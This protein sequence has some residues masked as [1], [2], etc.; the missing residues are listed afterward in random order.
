MELEEYLEYVKTGQVIKANSPAHQLMHRL[1]QDA[2][3]ITCVINSTYHTPEELSE[4]FFLP[5]YNDG[6]VYQ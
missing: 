3:K 2:M 4:L 6:L 1:S 5:F